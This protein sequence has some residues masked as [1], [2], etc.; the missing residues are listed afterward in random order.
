VV[1]T[2]PTGGQLVTA[3]DFGLQSLDF[4][5][6]MGSDNGQYDIACFPVPFS[7]GNPMTQV[8]VQ[9]ILSATGAEAAGAANLSART[10][11]LW[12]MGR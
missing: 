7:P 12:A 10:I 5:Q 8:R 6:C 11:R 3:T 1:G 4:V 9:W 2:P